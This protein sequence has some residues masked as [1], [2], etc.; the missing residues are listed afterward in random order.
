LFP[1]TAAV[2]KQNRG[3]RCSGALAA[4][5]YHPLKRPGRLSLWADIDVAIQNFAS[6]ISRANTDRF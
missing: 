3:A 2:A 6:T 1:S 4:L 5:I